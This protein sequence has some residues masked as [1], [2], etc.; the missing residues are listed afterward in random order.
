M[1]VAGFAGLVAPTPA[2]FAVGVCEGVEL[3]LLPDLKKLVKLEKV[4]AMP[5]SV[6][7]LRPLAVAA[8]R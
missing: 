8:V 2:G 7:C 4:R 1:A 5:G 3:V 6:F